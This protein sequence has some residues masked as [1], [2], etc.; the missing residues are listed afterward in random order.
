MLGGSFMQQL[1]RREDIFIDIL[2]QPELPLNIQLAIISRADTPIKAE[3]AIEP[4]D[5]R[6]LCPL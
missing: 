3:K 2:T 4:V 1:D 6:G 5:F